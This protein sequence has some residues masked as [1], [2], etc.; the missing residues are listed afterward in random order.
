MDQ[1]NLFNLPDTLVQLETDSPL[2]MKILQGTLS[3]LFLGIFL[4][5]NSSVNCSEGG[6][7][8]RDKPRSG[9]LGGS[10]RSR[11][12]ISIVEVEFD[13]SPKRVATL[14]R[15]ESNNSLN[16]MV[17]GPHAHL[18]PNVGTFDNCPTRF[19]V[20]APL[21]PTTTHEIGDYHEL[22]PDSPTP[23]DLD[24]QRRLRKLSAGKFQSSSSSSSSSSSTSS[25]SGDEK[26]KKQRRRGNSKGSLEKHKKRKDKKK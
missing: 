10:D 15:D 13:D 6:K 24:E 8:K 16:E 23:I 2:L 7:K 19:H 3:F 12:S 25:S 4:D 21:R 26:K 22:F 5:L 20:L 14:E 9:S 1:S 11:R 17:T 18:R